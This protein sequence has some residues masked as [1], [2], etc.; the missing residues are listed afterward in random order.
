MEDIL[1]W[2]EKQALENLRFHIQTSE[3]FTKESNTTL[4]LLFTGMGGAIAYLTKLLETK[5]AIGLTVAVGMFAIE[6]LLLAAVLIVSCLKT[7][8][9]WPPTNEPRFLFQ[10]SYV[11]AKIREAELNNIQARIDQM[12]SRNNRV[13]IWLDRVRL[14]AVVS[15]IVAAV[16]GVL[17]T[18][19]VRVG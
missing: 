11:L 3:H 7:D 18:V 10:P 9:V 2:V 17:C 13:A 5:A 16:A 1:E 14:G 8:V 19:L 6:M 15:P 4:T 12:V